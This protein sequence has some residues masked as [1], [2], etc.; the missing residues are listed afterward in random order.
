M[1]DEADQ[2]Q[3]V[4]ARDL[5]LA[6]ARHRAAQQCR[7]DGDDHCLDCGETI[8][9]ARMAAQP[10]APRCAECQGIHEH[11]QKARVRWV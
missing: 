7:D 2:A 9:A 8:P 3:V 5:D 4:E 6:L 1:A 10:G 11:R